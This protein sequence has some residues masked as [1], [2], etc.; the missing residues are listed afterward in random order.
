MHGTEARRQ[1]ADYRCRYTTPRYRASVAASEEP[2]LSRGIWL[3]RVSAVISNPIFMLFQKVLRDLVEMG[4]VRRARKA[5]PNRR[6]DQERSARSMLA[7]LLLV[8]EGVLLIPGALLVVVGLRTTAW[9]GYPLAFLGGA[10]AGFP[11][12]AVAAIRLGQL[13]RWRDLTT[14][15]QEPLR[16]RF[17][18]I[19]W[20]SYVAGGIACVVLV[21]VG[22]F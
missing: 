13:P 6:E 18:A 21:A 19:S 3:G 5:G 10:L 16:R 1:A 12:F 15:D 20:G 22:A 11:V 2:A 4:A 7:S 8:T 9:L 17:Q 14:S